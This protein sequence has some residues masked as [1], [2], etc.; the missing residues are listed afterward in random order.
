MPRTAET[1]VPKLI[2]QAC[3][4]LEAARPTD[5]LRL[6]HAAPGDLLQVSEVS[7]L[8]RLAARRAGRPDEPWLNALVEAWSSAGQPGEFKFMSGT[9]IE[10]LLSDAAHEALDE[11]DPAILVERILETD[12]V[13]SPLTVLL[14]R[15]W[16]GGAD[17]LALQAMSAAPKASSLDSR[18]WLAA[19]LSSRFISRAVEPA[20][21]AVLHALYDAMARAHPSD[22]AIVATGLLGSSS[23]GP[24]GRHGLSLGQIELLSHAIARHEPAVSIS[25]LYDGLV[26]RRGALSSRDRRHC[27]ADAVALVPF[28]LLDLKTRAAQ[29]LTALDTG[30]REQVFSLLLAVAERFSS[31]STILERLMAASVARMVADERGVREC[32]LSAEVELEHVRRVANSKHRLPLTWPIEPLQREIVDATAHDEWGLVTRTVCGPVAEN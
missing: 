25:G 29:A 18:L 24:E 28:P 23:E 31:A 11:D 13:A 4:L 32:Q 12:Y 8:A 20:A 27:F 6:L 21:R 17:A 19:L 26:G 9:P 22:F 15:C 2:G 7:V 14:A 3:E 10:D 5:V 16:R 1:D 30:G